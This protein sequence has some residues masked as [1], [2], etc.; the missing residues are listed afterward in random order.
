MSP[1][2]IPGISRK[3][4]TSFD[5]I[6]QTVCEVLE[7]KDITKRSRDRDLI[8]GRQMAMKIMRESSTLVKIGSYF[9]LDHATV[10]NAVRNADK[11]LSCEPEYKSL[12]IK[13]KARL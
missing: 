7:L 10:I 3:R 13:I 2:I 9:N 11:F 4:L 1:Y 8:K 6:C 12:F 5:M